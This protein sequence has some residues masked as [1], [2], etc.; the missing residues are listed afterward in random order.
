MKIAVAVRA[1]RTTQKLEALLASLAHSDQY[2]LFLAANETRSTIEAFGATK[3][4]HTVDIMAPLGATY[5]KE[6]SL[7]H[8]S[9][10]LFN[11]LRERL[12]LHDFIIVI[13]D[14]VHFPLGGRHFVDSV[15]DA[16]HAQ[17]VDLLGG[18]FEKADQSWFWYPKSKHAF[19]EIYGI[20]FPFIGMSA[21]AI[22]YLAEARRR[23]TFHLTVEGPVFC[24]AFVPSALVQSGGFVIRDVNELVPNSYR[25][26]MFHPWLPYLLEDPG[27][28]SSTV[29]MVHPVLGAQD[30]LQRH[31]SDAKEKGNVVRFIAELE[32]QHASIPASLRTEYASRATAVLHATIIEKLDRLERQLVPLD[33]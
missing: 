6:A 2:D 30:Y 7:V 3:L 1:H 9:D 31:F 4:V 28:M 14:D 16:V 24:E 23:E 13:E 19:A 25:N 8:C 27:W 33:K 12:P 20:Y 5:V 22:D 15:I 21:R 29:K 26:D 10:F 17:P 11:F 18:K 32:R